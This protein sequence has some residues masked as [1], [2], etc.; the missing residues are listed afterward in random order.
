MQRTLDI[1][2]S[3]AGLIVL[4]PLFIVVAIVL[5]FT[6]EH[7]IFFIQPRVGKN[8][9]LFGAYKFVTMVKNSQYLKTGTV[10]IKDDPRVLPFGKI[11]RKTKINELPQLGNVLLGHMS[12]VGP[13]PLTQR[14]F[15]AFSL[16]IQEEVTKVRPGLSGFGAIIFRGEE[17]LLDINSNPMEFYDR[18]IAPYKGE[19][20]RWYIRNQTIGKY[21]WVIIL[22]LGVVFFPKN[23]LVWRVFPDI[24]K[25][26]PELARFS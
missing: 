7:E 15:D 4:A 25:P 17:E 23:K 16:D 2:F 5:K 13:R 10:T 3:L 26:P 22:T 21:F 12:I 18:V 1:F 19:V 9:N 14:C 8:R 24:P 20:E 11:L 6:G